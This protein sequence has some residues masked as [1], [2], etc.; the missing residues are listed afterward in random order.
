MCHV[1]FKIIR[2][3]KWMTGEIRQ[4]WAGIHGQGLGW[5]HAGSGDHSIFCI[6]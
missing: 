4:D 6:C 5:V 3:G 2:E 1:C